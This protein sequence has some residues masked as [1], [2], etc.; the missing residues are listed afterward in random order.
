MAVSVFMYGSENWSLNRSYKRKIKA[1]E[2]RFFKTNGRLYTFV[3]KISSDIRE[4]LGIFNNNDK[5]THC[6]YRNT[7]NVMGR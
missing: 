7:T 1:A 6:K 2:I 4:Q 5:L 3:K